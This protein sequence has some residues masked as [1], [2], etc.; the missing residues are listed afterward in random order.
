MRLRPG[1][2]PAIVGGVTAPIVILGVAVVALLEPVWVAFEQGR[3]NVTAWT[4]FTTDQVNQVTGSILSDLVFGPPSFNVKLNGT[5][6]LDP[7][8]ISHMQDVRGVFMLLGLVALV[9]AVLFAIAFAVGSRR[10]VF[11]RGLEVGATV[12]MIGVV[13]VGVFLVT[14]FDQVFLLFH[15][16]FFAQGTFMFDPRTERL[17]QLFPDQFWNETSF[18]L[19]VIVLVLAWGLRTLARRRERSMT[20]E[21]VAVAPAMAPQPEEQGAR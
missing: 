17:V 11:W 15:D 8:E 16:I 9:A 14:L 12:F 6:V 19:A 4:G 5:Q 1:L 7:R 18:V 20:D 10:R 13:V 2:L 21:P 3:S